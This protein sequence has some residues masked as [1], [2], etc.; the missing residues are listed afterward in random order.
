MNKRISRV[1][2][3]HVNSLTY[4]SIIEIGDAVEAT[5]NSR[6]L[7]VQKEGAIFTDR[8]FPFNDF[9]VFTEELPYFD[10]KISIDQERVPCNP[11]IDVNSVHIEGISAASILQVGNL[12]YLDAEARVKHFRI[13]REENDDNGNDENNNNNENEQ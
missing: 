12:E 6:A 4:S 7:A 3:I 11:Y 10:K 2:D 5:P 13:L 8:D 1:G 9:P